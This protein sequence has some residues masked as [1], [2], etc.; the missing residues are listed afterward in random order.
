M[1]DLLSIM[2]MS[3]GDFSR[4]GKGVAEGRHRARGGKRSL[5][6]DEGCVTKGVE[7]REPA[8]R[9]KEEPSQALDGGFQKNGTTVSYMGKEEQDPRGGE[10][11]PSPPQEG[12]SGN[13][14]EEDMEQEQARGE[15]R[16][17]LGMQEEVRGA[18]PHLS[19]L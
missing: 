9:S 1:P 7:A 12:G 8:W 3:G 11:G 15:V 19:P 4:E 13:V 6:L 16:N 18:R 17:S 10:G 5:S 14:L 2:H